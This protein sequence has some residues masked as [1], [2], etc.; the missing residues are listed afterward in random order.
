M[1]GHAMFREH[2]EIGLVGGK[3]VLEN[4]RKYAYLRD[5]WSKVRKE[6]KK[7]CGHILALHINCVTSSNLPK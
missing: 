1:E 7:T 2:Q 3:A 6:W 5:R 4:T